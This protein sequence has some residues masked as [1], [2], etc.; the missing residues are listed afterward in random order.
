[1]RRMGRLGMGLRRAIGFAAA[2]GVW[3]LATGTWN[4]A[5]VWDDTDVWN[6]S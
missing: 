5:G 4:D 3:I 2:V 6:D 1:M